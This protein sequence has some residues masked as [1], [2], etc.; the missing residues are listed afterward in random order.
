MR[1]W[2]A[3]PVF[4]LSCLSKATGEKYLKKQTEIEKLTLI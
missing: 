4:L 2:I 1:H 3:S